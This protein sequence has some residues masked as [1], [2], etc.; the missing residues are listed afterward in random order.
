[1]ETSLQRLSVLTSTR[2]TALTKPVSI[3]TTQLPRQST[4]KPVYEHAPHVPGSSP[5]V[6]PA[7]TST[8]PPSTN[9]TTLAKSKV[10]AR[11]SDMFFD[12]WLQDIMEQDSKRAADNE[13]KPSTTSVTTPSSTTSSIAKPPSSSFL[14]QT[15]SVEKLEI[16]VKANG[17]NHTFVIDPKLTVKEITEYFLS[18]HP[19]MKDSPEP[20]NPPSASRSQIGSSLIE[21]EYGLFLP[22]P[23]G[24]WLNPSVK[25]DKYGLKQKTELELKKKQGGFKQKGDG[26]EQLLFLKVQIPNEKTSR[27]LKFD[28]AQNPLIKDVLKQIIAKTPVEDADAWA[29]L[30]F[31]KGLWLDPELPLADYKLTN[32][33]VLVFQ[34]KPEKGFFGTDYQ[35]LQKSTDSS[36]SEGNIEVATG[37]IILKEAL[38]K[39]NGF[40]SSHRL[41]NI[42]LGWT[43][44]ACLDF[45][46]IKL[47]SRT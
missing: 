10:K 22:F 16:I 37:L 20:L 43:K 8:N 25:L 30:Y 34:K 38:T 28:L 13:K 41:T 32:M 44:W 46:E 1:L 7:S 4:P 27:T 19:A 15:P 36:V 31:D 3:K 12:Q 45:Q 14:I 40:S 9:S 24:T 35:Q 21:F 33:Q 6:T 29:L 17:V 39:L 5:P 2:Q 18:N 26:G 23:L 47:E 11:E 42:S